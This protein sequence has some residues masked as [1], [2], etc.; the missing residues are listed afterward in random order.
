[1]STSSTPS[2]APR[3]P[4][5]A[6]FRPPRYMFPPFSVMRAIADPHDAP[7]IAQRR[8][9][10]RQSA[11]P[12]PM[13]D[14][15]F[16][17]RVV[18]QGKAQTV[19]TQNL[20]VRSAYD[21]LFVCFSPRSVTDRVRCPQ[22]CCRR[23]T[24][25]PVGRYALPPAS[26]AGESGVS[27]ARGC[28]RGMP[29]VEYLRCPA[30]GHLA[31]SACDFLSFGPFSDPYGDPRFRAAEGAN[32]KPAPPPRLTRRLYRAQSCSRKSE[33]AWSPKQDARL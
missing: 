2:S 27:S 17:A 10:I 4:P 8:R 7:D 11:S 6:A 28:E 33:R 20:E 21:R 22:Y 24:L 26:A 25:A 19:L 12:R 15:T 18:V 9:G 1:V 14:S 5:P 16:I 3:C 29:G 23:S 32:R 31:T 30:S 13:T